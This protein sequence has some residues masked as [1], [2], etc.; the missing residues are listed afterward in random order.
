MLL[1][2]KSDSN[3]KFSCVREF[4]TQ[5]E[6][7]K[8]LPSD[9]KLTEV[10]GFKPEKILVVFDKRLKHLGWVRKWLKEF[11]CT[12]AVDGGERVKDLSAFAGRMR[13]VLR[14]VGPFSSHSFAIISLGGGSVGDFAAFAASILKRGVPLIHI[15]STLLAAMDSAHGGKTALNLNHVKN[16]IGSF[17]PARA[18]YIVQSLF[19]DL[20]ALQIQ[21]AACELAKMAI[22]TGGD[23]FTDFHSRFELTFDGIWEFLPDA[24]AAK[25][26]V[27]ELDP[28]EMKGDRQVLNLGHSLG[29]ALESY[30]RLPHGLAV[31]EGLY[32]SVE[33]SR[34]RGYLKSAPA[35]ILQE[36]LNE[37]LKLM[38]P[39][40]FVRKYRQISREKLGRYIL[41]DK[42]LKNNRQLHFVF[43]EDIGRPL[44][45]SIPIESFL[46]ETQ[47]Q[48]WT[49]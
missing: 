25:Y 13:H 9:S 40:M 37:K 48:G 3:L 16:Q 32:F 28:F 22:L 18:I 24:I 17:W 20:P 36:V 27:V 5:V 47:R 34:H 41:E 15:P 4:E 46:V 10:L 19:E 2:P 29:H 39:Q 38:Q 42:K 49:A 7:L 14:Q 35:S 26:R 1:T 33:W 45:K 6:F 43:L 8:K 21:S 12:Y 23:F 11:D 30:Y 31:G 44:R